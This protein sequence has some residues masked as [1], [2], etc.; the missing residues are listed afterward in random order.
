MD[1]KHKSCGQQGCT[2][3]P[4]YGNA[5]GKPE[6]CSEHMKDGMLSVVSKRCSHQGCSKQPSYGRA[7]THKQEYC[8]EHKK[9]GM[10]DL[11]SKTCAEQGCSKGPYGEG[12]T[13]TAELCA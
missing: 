3:V 10:V 4:S 11:K 9:G 5:I 7:D 1:V 6:F 13:K 8:S 2:M 12:C